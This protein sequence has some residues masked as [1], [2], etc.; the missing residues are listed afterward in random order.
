M[1]ATMSV[2][3]PVAPLT[4]PPRLA[5]CALAATGIAAASAYLYW[6]TSRAPMARLSINMRLPARKLERISTLKELIELGQ[7][8]IQPEFVTEVL[9]MG[10]RGITPSMLGSIGQLHSLKVLDLSNTGL[11]SLPSSLFLNLP[12]LEVLNLAGNRLWML[13]STIGLLTSLRRLGL[14]SNCLLTIPDTVGD[15]QELVELYLTDNQ[16]VRLPASIGRLT[17]L[18]KLQASFNRLRELPPQLVSCERLE[19]LRVACCELESLPEVLERMPALSWFSVSGN[20]IADRAARAAPLRAI[21]NISFEEV[22]VTGPKLGAGASGD[23]T[24]ARWRGGAVAF[25]TFVTEVSPDGRAEDEERVACA[26]DDPALVRVLARLTEP[27]A[28]VLEL[29]NEAVPLADRPDHRSLLR[30][31][32]P[33]EKRHSLAVLLRIAHGVASAMRYLHGRGIA[34]GDLY[35]HNVLVQPSG[36]AVLCDYGAS[37]FYD[38][39]VDGH[40]ERHEVRAYG[41]LLQGLVGRLHV[42]FQGGWNPSH[43]HCRPCDPAIYRIA[44]SKGNNA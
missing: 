10:V 28:L 31:V 8:G 29:V 15:L 37:F 32:W 22:D 21:P 9:L 20:P 13:P 39:Q 16:L 44:L 38:R 17:S 43:M 14:K 11:E 12:R 3:E 36:R 34:H 30:C 6:Y 35:A 5:A 24:C 42:D 25:K 19:L 33:T 40:Y 4:V 23:V 1:T 27:H 18:V 41:L 7:G 2:F 26:L